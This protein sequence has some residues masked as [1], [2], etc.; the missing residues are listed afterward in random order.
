VIHRRRYAAAL[1][2]LMVCAGCRAGDATSGTTGAT[3]DPGATDQ[4]ST[5]IGPVPTSTTTSTSVASSE[6]GTPDLGA[7]VASQPGE[8]ACW[9]ASAVAGPVALT[10]VDSTAS[11][12]LVDPLTGV[13]GHAAAWGD[14]DGDL[15]PDLVVGTFAD[16]PVERYQERGATGPKPDTVFVGGSPYRA[17]PLEGAMGRTSGAAMVDLDNDGDLDVVLSR[18]VNSRQGGTLG[19]DV[20]RNDEG[21]LSPAGA[22]IDPD[23]SGRS[24]GVVDFDHD[25]LVDLFILEDH[26]AGGNSRLYR[27]VGDLHFED[28]TAAA[29]LPDGIH[30]LGIATGDVDRNGTEDVFVAGSNRLFLGA[31]GGFSEASL[32]V[33]AWEALGDEDDVAGA[34]FADVDLDGRLDLVVGHHYNSTVSRDTEVPIRLYLNRTVQPGQP[35]FEDVTEAAGLIP[36]PTK[37]PHV[38]FADMDNDGNVDIVTSA[39]AGDGTVPAVFLGLGVSDGIPRFEAPAGLGSD[40]YWT[41]APTVDA[42]RDGRLDVFALEWYPTLPSRLFSNQTGA[43]NWISVSIDPSLGPSVGT[44]VEVYAEGRAGDPGARLGYREITATLG[45]TAG[46]ELLAH[47]GLG[48]IAAVDVVVT[49]PGRSPVTLPGI[50]A[51]EHIRYPNGCG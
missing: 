12:D 27:N 25:G 23:L 37:A 51:N 36:L 16:K 35:R 34:A 31:D 33:F 18:N 48:A 32:P 49:L 28:A 2:L 10:L 30:G 5:T 47:F 44:A 43:G 24:I 42:D 21:R 7:V 9:T 20:Y 3:T 26:Y 19:T 8:L 40:Q 46:T 1:A 17:E 50:A 13:F 38:E 6:S 41:T 45:Y 4:G 29:G 22:G 14:L 11:A 39:S 15:I